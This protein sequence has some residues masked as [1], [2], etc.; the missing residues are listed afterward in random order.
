MDRRA[1]RLTENGH[2]RV[3]DEF[4]ELSAKKAAAYKVGD[5]F[6]DQVDQGPQAN[7]MQFEKVSSTLRRVR[8]EVRGV[9][10]VFISS[11]F[12]YLEGDALHRDW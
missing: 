3:Y 12:V 6:D 8:I 9:N 5:P 4:V 2:E 1:W 11:V 7:G 10:V